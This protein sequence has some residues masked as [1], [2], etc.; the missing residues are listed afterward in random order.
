[1]KNYEA[2]DAV[3]HGTI[4]Q[5]ILLSVRKSHYYFCEKG[6]MVTEVAYHMSVASKKFLNGELDE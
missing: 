5:R 2:M 4:Q 1:M 6:Q 3:F